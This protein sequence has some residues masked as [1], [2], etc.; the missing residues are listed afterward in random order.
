[1]KRPELSLSVLLRFGLAAFVLAA[2]GVALGFIG[3]YA[4]AS[5][6]LAI[7]GFVLTAVGVCVGAIAI[8][9]GQIVYG[10]KAVTGSVEAMKNL[11]GLLRGR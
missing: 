7:V 9:V 8:V 11:Q 3:W 4:V 1:M 5:R 10:R 2:A 6:S